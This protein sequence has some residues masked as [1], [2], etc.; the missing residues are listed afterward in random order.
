MEVEKEEIYNMLIPLGTVKMLINLCREN[1][2]SFIL[3]G[4]D[5]S[6]YEEAL[7]GEVM[8][9]C[10]EFY[11]PRE[12]MIKTNLYGEEIKTNK[13][14]LF[15]HNREQYNIFTEKF[16]DSFNF[17]MH[18]NNISWDMY[19]NEL[20]KASGIN[21]VIE[22]FKVPQRNSYAFGDGINDI[23]MF[24]IVEKGIS[25]GNANSELEKY[26]FDKTATVKDEGIYLALKKL[27]I[28]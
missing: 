24:Q 2:M 22:K 13:I 16:G 20:S 19:T 23:E 3:E 17:M 27:N 21:S 14:V 28:I 6:L 4:Q 1:K 9:F 18:P 15:I 11:I 26:A 12:K 8:D 25:M 10:E 7:E 5:L